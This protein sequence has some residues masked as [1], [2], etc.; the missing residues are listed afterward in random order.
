MNNTIDNSV[1]LKSTEL[2]NPNNKYSK[3]IGNLN[4]SLSLSQEKNSSQIYFMDKKGNL[5]YNKIKTKERE[6]YFLFKLN[7]R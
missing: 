1:N 5:S 4:D 3:N 2:N 7:F 6:V